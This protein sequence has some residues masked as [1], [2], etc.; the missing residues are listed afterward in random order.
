MTVFLGLA[1]WLTLIKF[2][3]PVYSLDITPTA[4]KRDSFTCLFLALTYWF[5]LNLMGILKSSAFFQQKHSFVFI[6]RSIITKWMK[7]QNSDIEITIRLGGY[8]KRSYPPSCIFVTFF[9][10]WNFEIS[11]ICLFWVA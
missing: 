11:S 4:K 6:V 7:F 5:N 8:P 9:F 2:G 3:S 10:T 1:F